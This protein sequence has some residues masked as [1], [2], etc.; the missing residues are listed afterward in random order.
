[1]F[2]T[3]VFSHD[4]FRV[5]KK[6]KVQSSKRILSKEYEWTTKPARN[7]NESSQFSFYDRKCVS[8]TS[9]IF[10]NGFSCEDQICLTGPA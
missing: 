10:W 4:L 3:Y 9:S 2:F 1:M 6:F 7:E 8:V 5:M